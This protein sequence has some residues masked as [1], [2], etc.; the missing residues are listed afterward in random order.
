MQCIAFCLKHVLGI[1]QEYLNVHR[2]AFLSF[3]LQKHVPG[4]PSHNEEGRSEAVFRMYGFLHGTPSFLE[5]YAV[6]EYHITFD[7]RHYGDEL[8]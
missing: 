7:L 4:V 2:T 5:F 6:K 3:H 8:Q 1:L